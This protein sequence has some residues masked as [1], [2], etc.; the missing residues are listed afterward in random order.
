MLFIESNVAMER[1]EA[2]IEAVREYP[3]LYN[4]RSSE[5]KVQSK[6]ENA[7]TAI[8]EQLERSGKYY[9]VTPRVI[10]LWMDVIPDN[11]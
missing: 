5:Y 1:D 8:A 7:W 2:L 6:K 11:S 4:S 3:Y 10:F 9:Y